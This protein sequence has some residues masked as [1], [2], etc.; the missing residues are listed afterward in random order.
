MRQGDLIIFLSLV[1]H[2]VLTNFH[3]LGKIPVKIEKVKE[4]GNV[5]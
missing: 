1:T 5:R 3:I 2:C 4:N